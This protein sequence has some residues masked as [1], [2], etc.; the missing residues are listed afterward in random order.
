M[1]QKKY[2]T[3]HEVKAD[4]PAVDFLTDGRAVFDIGGNKYRL[5]VT[6]RYVWQTVYIGH[7]LTHS[8]YDRLL[9]N[10]IL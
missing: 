8:D 3:P 5:V 2:Q 1:R 6:I 7:V 4:F 9:K 10:G